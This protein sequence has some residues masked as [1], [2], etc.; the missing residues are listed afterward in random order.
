MANS[1]AY[2]LSNYALTVQSTTDNL[3]VYSNTTTGN[4][5]FSVDGQG[6]ATVGSN[7]VL[8]GTGARIVGDF[9]NATTAS[10][11]MIQTSTANS[12]TVVSLIPNGSITSG[13]AATQLSLE[14]SGSIA[15]GNGSIASLQMAQNTAMR[16]V[17]A[18]RGTGTYLPMAFLTSGS[19]QMRL[20]TNGNLEIGT[21]TQT[22]NPTAT[23]VANNINGG[24]T[25]W[26]NNNSGGGNVSALSAGGLA[27]GTFTGAVGSEVVTERMRIDASGSMGIGTLTPSSY[28]NNPIL[29]L[30]RG[31][32]FLDIDNTAA[33]NGSGLS[34]YQSGT[35]K[36]EIFSGGASYASWGGAGS[37]NINNY[38]AGGP[39][40]FATSS[41]ERMRIDSSGNL[42]VGTTSAPTGSYT[43][44]VIVGSQFLSGGNSRSIA[45]AGTWTILSHPVNA[46]GGEMA[47][48]LRV[49]SRYSG[50]QTTTMFSVSGQGGSAGQISQLSSANYASGA[51]FT[52]TVGSTASGSLTIVYTNTSGSAVNASYTYLNMG[53]GT[54]SYGS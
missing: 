5:E 35:N 36:G 9:T 34:F 44:A 25:E 47:G 21:A 17:S 45:S 43:S 1:P 46:Y 12:F 29:A 33:S 8:S 13:A 6:N 4:T 42:L 18:I 2:G 30:S 48:I 31:G 19:E 7:L 49:F 54:P 16:L 15:T 3:L 53:G 14:D 20:T 51:S 28:S 32:A 26:V 52:V 41:T 10:R 38:A 22:A 37:I 39:I 23:L 50:Q 40:A 27:F 24:G 11:V